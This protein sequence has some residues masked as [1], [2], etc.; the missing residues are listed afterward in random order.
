MD[1]VGVMAAYLPVVR[2]CT[3]VYT[4]YRGTALRPVILEL[5]GKYAAITP[6]TSMS[7]DTIEPLL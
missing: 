6:I 7:T 5:T 1:V 3:T 2:V 4:V